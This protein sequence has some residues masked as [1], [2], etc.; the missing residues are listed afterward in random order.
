MKSCNIMKQICAALLLL[1]ALS[2]AGSV[3]V[4]IKRPNLL[5]L[6]AEDLGR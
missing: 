3:A 4:E 5:W 6:I 1:L 2:G